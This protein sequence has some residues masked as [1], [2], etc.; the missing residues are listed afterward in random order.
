MAAGNKRKHLLIVMKDQKPDY[1]VYSISIKH[2][3]QSSGPSRG[4]MEMRSLPSAVGQVHKPLSSPERIDFALAGDGATLAGVGSLKRT[5]TYDTRSGASSAGPELQHLKT[6]GTYVVPLGG[7]LYAL[8]RRLTGSDEGKPCGE[9]LLPA[10][11]A[12]RG[13]PDPPPDFRYMNQF[14]I[15][16]QLTA[17]FTAGARIWVSAEERGTYSFHTVRRSW[18]KEGDW[19]LPFCHRALLVPELDNLC[20][21]LCPKRRHLLAVDV[22]QSPPV[23]RYSWENTYPRWVHENGNL[24]GLMPECSLVYLGDGN[25]CIAWTVLMDTA[26][27]GRQN[28]IHL[29][30]VQIIKTSTL[31]GMKQLRIVKRRVCC[32]KMPSHGLMAYVF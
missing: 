10:D 17:Y 21:G 28:F 8:N 5:V 13:L 26:D 31:S 29:M 2:L 6:G 9:D 23:V 15:K 4:A 18:R 11:G 32:Y 30:A 16:C 27:G 25:F 3:F 12:W 1:F 19:E 14:Q 24:C 22:Q 20:F 7:R